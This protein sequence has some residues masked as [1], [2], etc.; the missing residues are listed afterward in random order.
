MEGGP[1][2]R[3]P[4]PQSA[5]PAGEKP[6]GGGGAFKTKK[7]CVKPRGRG[8]EEGGGGAAQAACFPS[9]PA[10]RTSPTLG[11]VC[12]AGVKGRRAELSH[13]FPLHFS[14]T[15]VGKGRGCPR[16]TAAHLAQ[17]PGFAPARRQA[18]EPSRAD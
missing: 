11:R 7:C 9:N 15:Q 14:P 8:R 5:G 3:C 16:V 17:S 6:L 13:C 1:T 12:G 18:R 4:T 2:A 10:E